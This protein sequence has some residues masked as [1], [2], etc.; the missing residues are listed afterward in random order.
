MGI[1]YIEGE[2]GA[3]GGT[4]GGDPTQIV[5]NTDAEQPTLNWS[6]SVN[7]CR[8]IEAELTRLAEL[9]RLTPDDK[10]YFRSLTVEF[11]KVDEHRQRL[12]RVA[13]LEKVRGATAKID[14][15]TGSSAQRLGT[16]GSQIQPEARTG[17]DYDV[18]AFR[19]PD[20]VADVRFRNPWDVRD[21]RTFGRSR[22]DVNAE[23]RSRAVTAI[24]RMPGASD[25]VREAST[26][27]LERWDDKDSSIA[28]MVLASSS[29]EYVRAFSKLAQ[30]Q[31]HML[32]DAE[33][34]SVDAV[35][36][37]S[38]TNTAGG[39][40]VPFQMDPTVI[41]TAN[42]SQNDIRRLARNVVATGTR[43]NGV[44]AGAVSWSWDAEASQVSDDAP[45]FASPGIDIFKAQG[46]VPISIEA[47]E[48]EQNVGATV[49]TLLA[50]GREILESAAF[51]LG[52]GTGQPKGIVTALA[53]TGSVVA[54]A[55]ADTLAVGDLYAVQG[56]LPARFRRNGA[57]LANNL[58]YNRARQFDTA[59]GSALWAQLGD[60]RPAN[61]LGYPIY[62]AEDMDG[63][64][65]ATQENYMAVYGDFRNYVIADRIGMTVE[66]IPHLFQQTTA[67]TGTGRPTGQRGWFAYYRT[68]ADVVNSAAF[69]M[70][71]VT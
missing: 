31:S 52:T 6:Q 57:W 7:R 14:V 41:V 35:R 30:D 55:T 27:I 56:S 23:L 4:T 59:G 32:T 64:I 50:E 51:I 42:G 9:D 3:G 17:S 13:E 11:Q 5:V 70:L 40:L 25:K 62:E 1:R 34:R 18:D 65:N 21:V 53:G 49:A 68:G 63:V 36:A 19:N 44:T 58:F 26:A 66:F 8:E 37:M 45:T 20:E 69:R 2:G 61:L 24:E 15:R 39:Y 48:D 43:W 38:L 12:E 71:N 10:A 47:L 33:K 22:E 29:P 28:R 67:G 54:S 60:G 16:S 46:F